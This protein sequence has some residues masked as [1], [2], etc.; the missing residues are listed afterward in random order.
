MYRYSGQN[1]DISLPFG[2]LGWVTCN[3]PLRVCNKNGGWTWPRAENLGDQ[4]PTQPPSEF[5]GTLFW[6]TAFWVNVNFRLIK[7]EGRHDLTLRK[8]FGGFKKWD[9]LQRKAQVKHNHTSDFERTLED[10]NWKVLKNSNLAMI[11]EKLPR[12]LGMF[13][14]RH[15]RGILRQLCFL[16]MKLW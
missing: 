5:E 2:P 1:D 14:S 12:S 8:R 7:I 13:L 11:S 10:P 4:K 3:K 15:S 16:E 9:E 6:W